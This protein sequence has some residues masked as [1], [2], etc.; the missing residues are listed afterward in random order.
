MAKRL[1]GFVRDIVGKYVIVFPRIR[2]MM[3]RVGRS[4]YCLARGEQRV[5]DMRLDGE[6]DLQHRVHAANR[7]SA[8]FVAFDIGANQGDWTLALVESFISREGN[9]DRLE[10]HAFEPVPATRERLTERVH[11]AT[12]A[13][14]HI[15]PVALS[16][17]TGTF[18]MAVMSDT[19]G[20]KFS[21]I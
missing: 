1:R 17:R 3:W 9:T 4:L 10:V 18:D 13:N 20:D 5:D 8:C 6:L 7:D 16:D 11:A 21:C 2:R 14:V 15:N 19:G 12:L